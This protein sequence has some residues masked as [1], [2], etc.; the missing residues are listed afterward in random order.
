MARVRGSLNSGVL[1]VVMCV[2]AGLAGASAHAGDSSAGKLVIVKAMYGDLDGDKTADVTAKVAAMVKDNSLSVEASAANF[3]DPAR[4]SPKQL[5]VSY[6]L[7]GVY[8][9]KTVDE[10]QT[11]DISTR[12][13]IRKAV[14]GDSASG[15]TAD[16]TE[17]VADLVRKN[18]LS[19]PAG[20]ELF[21]GDPAPGVVKQ[22]RVDY[23]FDGIDKTKTVREGQTLT[24]TDQGA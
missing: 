3:G 6:T 14:Y 19:V 11:L 17:Q 12:L 1:A 18:S 5:K 7:D 2:C 10:G 23:T 16:V 15:K 21:G 13:F 8:R 22:L 20:N 24:I 4:G 9:S